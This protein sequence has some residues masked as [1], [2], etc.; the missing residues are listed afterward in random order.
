MKICLV[1]D[2]DSK[3]REPGL[4]DLCAPIRKPERPGLAKLRPVGP[5]ASSGLQLR[6]RRLLHH[7]YAVPSGVPYRFPGRTWFGC[8][9]SCCEGIELWKSPSRIAWNKI[10]R[11]RRMSMESPRPALPG[12]P[13]CVIC[14]RYGEYIC[15]ETDSDICSLE[16]KQVLLRKVTNSESSAR[17]PATDECYYVSDTAGEAGSRSLS[18]NQT[19]LLRKKLD[20]FVKGD[21]VPLPI[22]SFSSCP[23]P[24]KLILNMEAAGYELPTPVQMQAIPAALTG[25]SLLV[26]ADTGTGKTASF[27]VPIISQCA[28]RGFRNPLD[29]KNPLAIVLEP[30][31]EL[32]IQVEEQAKLLG[33]GLPFKT[34]LVVGG[35]P[36]AG[37]IYRIQQGV[38]LIV[39]T[40]GR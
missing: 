9:L 33:K 8:S 29:R 35:D 28:I 13:K 16:C 31:R 25:K 26:S 14:G 20:I 39:G 34:A 11:K 2:V 24:Q 7:L 3:A 23:L 17:L 5:P 12:D 18:A 22:L 10:L 19:S 21:S 37:Q 27:L 32:C 36:M 1:P 15:D 6:R 30:T 38:E 40:P 4:F